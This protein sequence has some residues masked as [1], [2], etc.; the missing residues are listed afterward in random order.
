MVNKVAND[1]NAKI[2]ATLKA[3]GLTGEALQRAEQ[4]QMIF[5][6]HTEPDHTV[7]EPFNGVFGKQGTRDTDQSI[8]MMEP[9]P[10]PPH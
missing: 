1:F 7:Q 2:A 6:L 8:C 9:L 5:V 4:E 10:R 3:Q